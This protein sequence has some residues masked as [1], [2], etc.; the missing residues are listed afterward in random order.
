MLINNNDV[1]VLQGTDIHGLLKIYNDSTQGT[2]F[3]LIRR[4]GGLKKIL[5]IR[6][7]FGIGG[8]GC[9]I[10]SAQG[11]NNNGLGNPVSIWHR[12]YPCKERRTGL[13]YG[14]G[15]DHVPFFQHRQP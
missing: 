7:A 12:L 10:Y 4:G 13:R 15:R 3:R 11:I 5:R 9:Y 8:E 6:N 14:G 2:N 1:W